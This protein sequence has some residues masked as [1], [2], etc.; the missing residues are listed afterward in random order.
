MTCDVT[1]VGSL[2]YLT[3][4]DCGPSRYTQWAQISDESAAI[5]VQ[6][7]E[8]ILSSLG[9]PSEVLSDNSKSFRL[10]IMQTMPL[11]WG[12]NLVYRAVQKPSGNGIVERIHRAVKRIN[13][14]AQCGVPMAVLLV[15]NVSAK[16]SAPIEIFS[17]YCR[18]VRVPGVN[19]VEPVR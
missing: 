15:N 17:Q 18:R 8:T 10:Q 3:C 13:A 4:I 1:H 5:V 14:R 19:K 12:I 11:K 9:P 2:L 16:H 6:S 7:L